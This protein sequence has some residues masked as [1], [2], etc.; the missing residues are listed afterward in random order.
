[1]VCRASPLPRP[2]EGAVKRMRGDERV[3]R[4]LGIRA[5]ARPPVGVSFAHE[6]GPNRVELDV[7]HAREQVTPGEHRSAVVAL[8]PDAVL[9]A[10]GTLEVPRIALGGRA[11]EDARASGSTQGRQEM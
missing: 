11:H 3:V 4:A 8:V 7:A 6:P 10:I 1:S 2:S 9:V 5:V